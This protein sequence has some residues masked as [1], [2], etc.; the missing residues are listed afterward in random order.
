MLIAKDDGIQ[1]QGIIL[2]IKF[3]LQIGD[4]INLGV[5]TMLA[6]RP[7]LI[8]SGINKRGNLGDD[9]TYS[10]TVSAA[11]EGTSLRIPFSVISLV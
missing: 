1:S 3:L 8:V 2:A 4:C 9:I 7:Q 6:R 10:G 5:N 11:F